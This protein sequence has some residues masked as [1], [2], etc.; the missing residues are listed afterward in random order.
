MHIYLVYGKLGG[1]AIR[2]GRL[3]VE[4]EYGGG[5]IEALHS[6]FEGNNAENKD[7]D[8]DQGKD[9]EA[10]ANTNDNDEQ[11]EIRYVGTPHP[12]RRADGKE[13]TIPPL[14]FSSSSSSSSP[15][16]DLEPGELPEPRKHLQILPHPHMELGVD[17]A[18]DKVIEGGV[19][20]REWSE[21][22]GTGKGR[23][24]WLLRI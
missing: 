22:C 20:E 9:D 4:M 19:L 1:D 2:S 17:M 8:Q 11:E 24:G 18:R 10:D 23:R 6:D 13:I 5:R 12:G 15:P 21:F 14:P 3:D 7:Q 16:E